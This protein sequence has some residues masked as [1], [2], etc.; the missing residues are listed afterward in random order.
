MSDQKKNNALEQSL[1]ELSGKQRAQAAAEQK[2]ARKWKIYGIATIVVVA[3]IAALLFWDS[4]VIQRSATAVT[5]GENKYSA[6]EVDYYYYSIYDNMYAYASYYG[7][8]TNKSLK[9]QEFTEGT[10]WYQYI[11]DNAKSSLTNVA[12]LAQEAKAAGY[13]MSD[14]SK[15]KVEDEIQ[16]TKDSAKENGVSYSY[17]LK[18]MFG[19]LMT[20]SIYQKVL[21]EYEYAYAFEDDKTTSF[22]VSDADIQSYYNENKDTIDTYDF[23]CYRVNALP[24]DTDA[25]GNDI[26]PTKDDYTK[27]AKAAQETA[28]QL[29]A[30][31]TAGDTAKAEQLAD[32]ADTVT[33]LSMLSS[34]SF[35]NYVFGDWMTDPARKAGDTTVQEETTQVALTEGAEADTEV[36][37]NYFVTLFNNRAL[38]E[39]YA[40]NMH[41]ILVKATNSDDT[42]NYGSALAKAEEL[43]QKFE[44]NGATEEAFLALTEEEDSKAEENADS[45]VEAEN[46]DDITTTAHFYENTNKGILSDALEDWMFDN[47]KP[48]DVGIVEDTQANG[49]QLVYFVGYD[50]E[51]S[52]YKAARS[53]IQSDLYGD[54]M[55]EVSKNYEAKETSFFSYVG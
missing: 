26:T 52:W 5:V 25:D 37:S 35:S 32:E 2:T 45:S 39:Y 49:Y 51:Y 50:D 31:L 42:T 18:R 20:P 13:E 16:K 24:E 43:K 21:N 38:D 7:L 4:G 14:E 19:R 41:T 30:A 46:T 12:T 10:T 1:K 28:D 36:V 34:S 15:A 9:E 23:V 44:A 8:D 54:W 47:R 33:N 6:A 11:C 48:G 29:K 22:E 55:D 27:A 53:S 3:L 40:G 17:Y